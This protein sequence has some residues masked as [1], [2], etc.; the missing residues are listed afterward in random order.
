MLGPSVFTGVR[1]FPRR[2]SDATLNMFNWWVRDYEGSLYAKINTFPNLI[3]QL[4]LCTT[5]KIG[6]SSDLISMYYA[7]VSVHCHPLQHLSR[8]LYPSAGWRFWW[9]T[10]SLSMY[11]L[12]GQLKKPPSTQ[13]SVLFPGKW[14]PHL[15]PLLMKRKDKLSVRSQCNRRA[16]YDKRFP[17]STMDFV[18]QSPLT[19]RRRMRIISCPA[20]VPL[21]KRGQGSGVATKW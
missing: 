13:E 1:P 10:P 9:I 17:R 3:R 14:F 20:A 7:N 18:Y 19:E 5:R 21:I 12:G 6:I 16:G 4:C 8:F 11:V 15:C 2:D